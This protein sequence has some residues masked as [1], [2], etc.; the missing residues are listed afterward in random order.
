ME[1]HGENPRNDRVRNEDALILCVIPYKFQPNPYTIHEHG[2]PKTA[3][4]RLREID[5]RS[6]PLPKDDEMIITFYI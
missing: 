5:L 6:E 3:Q 1:K 2:S 4:P